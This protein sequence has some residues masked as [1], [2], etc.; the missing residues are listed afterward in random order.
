MAFSLETS[1]TPFWAE[2]KGF[3]NGRD[4]LGIQNSSV[5]IYAALLP[6]LNNVTDRLRYY[7]FYCWLLKKIE[8]ENLTFKDKQDHFNYI[9]K[10][11]YILAVYMSEC[12]PEEQGI[13]GS[14]YAIRKSNEAKANGLTFIDINSGAEKH[15]GTAKGSVFW[16][17]SA[18]ILGQYYA[19]S[20]QSN[21]TGLGLIRISEGY[22]FITD[23]GKKLGE[24]YGKTIG[25][26]ALQLFDETLVKGLLR[27]EDVKR[28][29]D[30]SIS[31]IKLTSEEGKFYADMLFAADYS[32]RTDTVAETTYRR[33]SLL[34]FIEYMIN[35]DG[36]RGYQSLPEML[37]EKEGLIGTANCTDASIG[38]F[39]YYCCERMHISLEYIF[40]NL[41]R[42]IEIKPL[43]ITEVCDNLLEAFTLTY[44]ECYPTFTGSE[45]LQEVVNILV[46]EDNDYV[47]VMR[48]NPKGESLLYALEYFLLTYKTVKVHQGSFERFANNTRTRDKNGTALDLA[49][50]VDKNLHQPIDV[51]FKE[52][53]TKIV[54][55]HFTVAYA[56][57]GNGEEQV[58]KLLIEDNRLV[59]INNIEPRL[60]TPRLKTVRNFLRDMGVI[61]IGE[62]ERF[63]LT[64]EG[65]EIINLYI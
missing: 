63:S 57:M 42:E 4:P 16:D 15:K 11:E 7:G 13:A 5:S 65:N 64:K 50:Y 40:D 33:D 37:Y 2:S 58:H 43:T 20:L 30:F 22:Y 55:D 54:N 10:A 14:A 6:G 1:L 52:L 47:E 31:K 19:G 8:D 12:E 9:R 17:F 49:L 44:R 62:D 48:H 18:G 39:Y 45:T 32:L 61:H 28:L 35:F 41:L 23:E 24:A 38:W 51:F 27:F 59:H 46:E 34:L 36:R 60:T 26:D 56:K 21:Y 29:A 53:C 3:I 25:K